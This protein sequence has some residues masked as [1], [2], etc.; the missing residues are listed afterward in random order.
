MARGRTFTGIREQVDSTTALKNIAGITDDVSAVVEESVL[1]PYFRFTTQC[2]VPTMI[3]KK[4]MSV[5]CL[6]DGMN[7][8]GATADRFAT[9]QLV[10]CDEIWLQP[11]ITIEQAQRTAQ[12]TVTHQ[13]S[14]Q[15]RMIAPFDVHLESEGT[16]YKRFWI[17]RIGDSRI[18]TDSVTGS[19]HP[20]NAKSA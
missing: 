4:G 14:K 5:D 16:I 17:I 19:M 15:L 12:R 10:S 9:D 18:M 7:N 13:L 20:L 1:Y 11:R 2:T 6:V 8:L 3:G